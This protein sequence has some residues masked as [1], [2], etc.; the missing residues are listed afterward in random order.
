[1]VEGWSKGRTGIKAWRWARQRASARAGQCRK[2]M[3]KRTQ[4][5]AI[6][7]GKAGAEAV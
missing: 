6:M 3:A 7:E 1:M 5:Q 4:G 2:G